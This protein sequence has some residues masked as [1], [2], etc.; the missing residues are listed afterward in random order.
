MTG[1]QTC[2]LP[3][4]LRRSVYMMLLSNSIQ[5]HTSVHQK[6]SH[7][8]TRCFFF[9]SPDIH[10]LGSDRLPLPRS[11]NSARCALFH[12]SP[13]S[14]PST[15]S[16]PIYLFSHPLYRAPAPPGYILILGMFTPNTTL[17]TD[18]LYY[19]EPIGSCRPWCSK[20]G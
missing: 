5:F 2:A 15:A 7:R 9:S 14:N 17:L 13:P 11:A 4:S 12:V 18:P 3:I 19:S 1:V 16:S 10:I 20:H 8:F 6:K